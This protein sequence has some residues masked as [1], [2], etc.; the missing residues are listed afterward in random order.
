M[1]WLM[2][3]T[4]GYDDRMEE[5]YQRGWDQNDP[6]WQCKCKKWNTGSFCEACGSSRVSRPQG[7]RRVK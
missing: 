6:S 3:H 4:Q 1:A 7:D 2:E 5:Y